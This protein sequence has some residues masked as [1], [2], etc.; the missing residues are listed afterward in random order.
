M[1]KILFLVYGLMTAIFL[2]GCQGFFDDYTY[3]PPGV[4]TNSY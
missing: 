3:R 2:S 1:R 4:S